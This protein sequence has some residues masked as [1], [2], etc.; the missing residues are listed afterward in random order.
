MNP[1]YCIEL[2]TLTFSRIGL[3]S[4]LYT[5]KNV[6][7]LLCLKLETI[8]ASASGQQVQCFNRDGSVRKTNLSRAVRSSMESDIARAWINELVLLQ[9]FLCKL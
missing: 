3:F 1:I 4:A 6:L 7:T 9:L 8:S 2:I 5:A